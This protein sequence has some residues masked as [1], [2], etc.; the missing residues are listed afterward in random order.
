[1]IF[2]CATKQ[3]KIMHVAGINTLLS[4]ASEKNMMPG[5]DF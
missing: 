3:H 2:F 4:V 1:M 5:K